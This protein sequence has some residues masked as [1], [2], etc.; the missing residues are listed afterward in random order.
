MSLSEIGLGSARILAGS[1]A[2]PEHLVEAL[3]VEPHGW[4][5]LA[6]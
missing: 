3:D 4:A 1:G 6:P 2:P 5:I